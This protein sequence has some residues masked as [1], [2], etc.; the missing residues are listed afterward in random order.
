MMT[1]RETHVLQ[2]PGGDDWHAVFDQR[3]RHRPCQSPEHQHG[4]RASGLCRGGHGL[5]RRHQPQVNFVE[6][7]NSDL[8]SPTVLITGTVTVEASLTAGARLL[9]RTMPPTSKR[10]LGLQFVTV[11]THT[12][13]TIFGGLVRDID[14]TSFPAYVTGY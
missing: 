9:A 11:G 7:A 5:C 8:S 14:D 4:A 6:S 3:L 1:D 13:G 10:Y 12:A 2:Q